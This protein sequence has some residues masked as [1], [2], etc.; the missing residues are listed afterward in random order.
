MS[1][2][3]DTL[4]AI[5]KYCYLNDPDEKDEHLGKIYMLAHSGL[6]QAGAGCRNPHGSWYKEVEKLKEVEV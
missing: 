1:K 6:A 2:A 5:E 4:K 3:L